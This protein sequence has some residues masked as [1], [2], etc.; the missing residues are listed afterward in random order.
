ML[1]KRVRRYYPEKL[2][3]TRCG[4]LTFNIYIVRINKTHFTNF[5]LT[6]LPVDNCSLQIRVVPILALFSIV[7]IIFLCVALYQSKCLSESLLEASLRITRP[8]VSVIFLVHDFYGRVSK[9]FLS[10]VLNSTASNPRQRNLLDR[11]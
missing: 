3:S 10:T 9:I 2:E 6:L 5:I 1:L 7:H 11:S 4:T 8:I